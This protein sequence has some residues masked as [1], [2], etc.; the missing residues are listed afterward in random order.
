M[1]HRESLSGDGRSK[2]NDDFRE[3]LNG[4]LDRVKDK[5]REYLRD[6]KK[7]QE[8]SPSLDIDETAD[9]ILSS[10]QGALLQAKVA[11]SAGPLRVF[12]KTI[13]E[14]VLKQ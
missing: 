9:F 1:S 7:K 3:K 6:A 5:I 14:T 12:E 10:F 8:V 11:K 2:L 4:V 13:F